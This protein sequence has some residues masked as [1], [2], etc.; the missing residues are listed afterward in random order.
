MNKK[1]TIS[2]QSGR[3]ITFLALA[4]SNL[5]GIPY[6]RNKTMYEWC[7]LCGVDD[8]GKLKWKDMILISSISFYER[9]AI[10]LHYDRFISDGISFTEL[11]WLKSNFEKRH[12]SKR[13]NE[14]SRIIGN[15]EKVS[16]SYAAQQYNIIIHSGSETDSDIFD[17]YIQMYEKF[18]LTYKVYN[19]ESPETVVDK[20]AFD[21]KLHKINTVE[22]AIYKA[23]KDICEIL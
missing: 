18:N 8:S 9:A 5:T 1:I 21:L 23:K 12:L 10:E 4:L 17:L 11:I 3:N 22:Y 13:K 2:G 20:I 6:I 19:T 15:M 14:W 7:K 16:A